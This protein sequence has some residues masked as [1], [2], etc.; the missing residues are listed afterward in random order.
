[1][2][3]KCVLPSIESI[4][5]RWKDPKAYCIF[6]MYFY[7]AAV[8]EV[9][10]KECLSKEEGRIGSNTM[11]AFAL[12]VLVNNYKAWLY[13][14]KKTHKTKLLTEYDFPPSYGKPSIVDKILDGIQFN[15]EKEASPTVI[16][17]KDDRTYKKLEKE[18]V[19]WLEAFCATDPC[20]QT[21]EGV[22]KKTSAEDT[23]DDSGGEVAEADEDLI[24]LKVRAKKKRKFTRELR[25]FTGVTSQSER[26]HKG[27]SDEGMEAFERYVKEIRKDA[28]E[29]KYVAWEKAY[30]D[31][32]EKLGRSKKDK[33]EP[34]Q[35][36]RYKPNLGVVYEGF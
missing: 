3:N 20:L 33:E 36:A 29:D 13:E 11:E 24:D 26:K 7:T 17:D 25:E 22:L 18:R 15:L 23:S 30:R 34:F 32:M 8:G 21:N 27:W 14:E 9:H 5:R 31:V 6:Y 28:E 12:L 1:V 10:W 19:E 4:K 16:Y 35:K 2:E